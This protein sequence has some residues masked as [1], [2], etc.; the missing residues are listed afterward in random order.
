MTRKIILL[1]FF[2]VLLFGFA[3]AAE[4]SKTMP[5]KNYKHVVGNEPLPNVDVYPLQPGT[6]LNDTMIGTSFYE[7][8]SNGSSGDRIVICEDGS[9]YF[10]WMKLFGWPYPPSP[11]HIYYNWI[12]PE[13]NLLNPDGTQISDISGSGYCQMSYIFGNRGAIAYHCENGTNPTYVTLAIEWDPPGSGFYDY[14]NPPDEIFPQ[15]PDS[16]GRLFWPYITVDRNNHIHIVSTENTDRRIQRMAY[17][18]SE[19]AGTTWTTLE[20]VDTVQVISS[21]LDAS[22]VSDRVI[23]AYAKTQDTTTQWNN[24]IVYFSSDSGTAWDWRYG[25]INV[26]DY[27]NDDDSLWAYTDLDAIIDYNDY[28]HIIWNAQWVIDQSVHYKTY[29]FH[30]SEETGEITEITHHPD[31]LWTN[32]SGVWNR[33]VCKMSL[34]IIEDS[35]FSSHIFTT[36]TQFDTSDVSAAGFGNGELYASFSPDRGSTWSVP[37][38]LT[39]SQ[40][41]GCYPGECESDHW[42]SLADRV[43]LIGDHYAKLRYTYMNDKDAGAVIQDPPEGV[44]TENPV[45]Y[46][47][48]LIDLMIA[49]PEIDNR[50]TNFSLNQNYPNPFNART[51]IS[52]ELEKPSL[53]LLEIY[54][55]TGAKVETL[56]DELLPAGSHDITW[57]ANNVASGVYY[58]KLTDSNS[59]E[60]RQAVLIK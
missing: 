14:F 56:T 11:R 48:F 31:S 33:P 19:D 20:L 21:V 42:S 38:N 7:Y 26:T 30:Y 16:P 60:T 10:C 29:L 41:S 5:A 3:Q 9:I 17:T 35:Q 57:N 23:L 39:N 46:G 51:T 36:W 52:F 54:D 32:I 8:Q 24:D 43:E 6:A 44:A 53:V 37:V 40:S 28:V 34:G 25:M 47:E 55:I 50:P 1:T 15:S 49:V 27:G 59:S 13:G 18:R 22:P 4:L 45:I 12:S 2:V 58:Y